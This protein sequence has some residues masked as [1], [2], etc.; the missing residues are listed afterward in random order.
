MNVSLPGFCY[1]LRSDTFYYSRQ[2]HGD[3]KFSEKITQDPHPIWV[4][5]FLEMYNQLMHRFIVLSF[6]FSSILRI[7]II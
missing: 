5:S 4:I 6:C 1:W 7:Q 2:V 3:T